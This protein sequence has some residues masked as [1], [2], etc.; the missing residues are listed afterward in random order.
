MVWFRLLELRA[1]L[2]QFKADAQTLEDAVSEVMLL[3]SDAPEDAPMLLIGEA[4]IVSNED[5]A[6]AYC[7]AKLDKVQEN[8]EALNTEEASIL[9]KQGVL[10][11]EL[12]G[13]FGD[14]INLEN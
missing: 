11:K 14:S 5:N 6:T 10:K 9:E 1:D 2:T 3:T 7:Q 4:F 8:I 12:Y 13:R